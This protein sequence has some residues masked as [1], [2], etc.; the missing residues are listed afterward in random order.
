MRTCKISLLRE[1]LSVLL[2]SF[3]QETTNI[4]VVNVGGKGG[5]LL[6][7]VCSIKE[8]LALCTFTRARTACRKRIKENNHRESSKYDKS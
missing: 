6:R 1:F 2:L 8:S 5:F 7:Q 3:S 4:D